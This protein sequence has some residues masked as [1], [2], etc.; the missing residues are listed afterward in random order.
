MESRVASAAIPVANA[1]PSVPPGGTDGFAFATGMAAEA[2]LLSIFGPGDHL[3]VHD[4]LYGGTYRLLVE[5]VKSKGVALD[6]VN[7]RDL[8]ALREA[9]RPET[10][11]IWIE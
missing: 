5:V 6:F 1:N 3:I 2:T 8:D 4:D 11:A 10:S 7:L 9:I